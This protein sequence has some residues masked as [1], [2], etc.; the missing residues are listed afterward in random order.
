ME[1]ANLGDSCLHCMFGNALLARANVVGKYGIDEGCCGT[2]MSAACCPVC[3]QY[4]LVNEIL[5]RE[6]LTWS[7]MSVKPDGK[8]PK[9][10]GMAQA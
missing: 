1:Q 6:G 8:G 9:P 3:S 5:V 2:F 10:Q 4:Q 7:I